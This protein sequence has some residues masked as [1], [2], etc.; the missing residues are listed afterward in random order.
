MN[1]QSLPGFGSL[2][3]RPVQEGD[4]E[5]LSR[6]Y[7]NLSVRSQYFFRP[8]RD[9]SPEAM[10]HVVRQSLE[11]REDGY[12][13]L[14]REGEVIGHVF[15]GDLSREIPHLGIGLADERQNSG[16]GRVLM[17]FLIAVG[18]R[19]LGKKAIGLSVMKTNT[20]A[21][22]VYEN[23]G[24]RICGECTFRSPNDSYVMQL[25]FE[26]PERNGEQVLNDFFSRLLRVDLAAVS[27]GEFSV[28]PL[29]TP[30]AEEAEGTEQLA[31]SVFLRRGEGVVGAH[32][33]ILEKV[34]DVVSEIHPC[35][36]VFAEEIRRHL[37]QTAGQEA[38]RGGGLVKAAGRWTCFF[39]CPRGRLHVAPGPAGR[40]VDARD[41]FLFREAAGL[42]PGEYRLKVE[43]NTQARAVIQD[44]KVA[45]SALAFPGAP[46][47]RDVM[48]VTSGS[49]PRASA[50]IAETAVLAEMILQLQREGKEPV[51]ET[52][53]DD[54]PRIQLCEKV[55]MIK[56]ADVF[57]VRWEPSIEASGPGA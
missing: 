43:A 45:A 20:R 48:L 47:N 26:T 49:A 54:V 27:R 11:G 18:R 13:C 57:R 34:K 38:S 50:G 30:R 36:G 33:D 10:E 21:I 32:R 2:T 6:F 14:D 23:C 37:V 24:F 17:Q 51:A 31:V 35:E 3:I 44:G 1:R 5:A 28:M 12:V 29:A 22:Q 42:C 9:P 16:L 41:Q 39:W 8:Y 19:K 7:R 40:G 15:Y 4:G 53:Y 52:R 46:G 55:G 56:F 25:D